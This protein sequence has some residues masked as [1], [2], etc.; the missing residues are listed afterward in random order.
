VNVS[1][2]KDTISRVMDTSKGNEDQLKETLTADAQ[3]RNNF[4]EVEAR[5]K[6]SLN[7][8]NKAEVTDGIYEKLSGLTQARIQD[9]LKIKNEQEMKKEDKK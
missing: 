2:T 1:L 4:S 6:F 3:I 7:A 9:A 5:F 8:S